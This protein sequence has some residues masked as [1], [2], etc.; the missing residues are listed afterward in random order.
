M[1]HKRKEL[2]HSNSAKK[3][4]QLNSPVDQ[5]LMIM[6]CFLI[7]LINLVTKNF[8]LD[9][10]F[11]CELCLLTLLEKVSSIRIQLL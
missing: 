5:N 2:T 9:S 1:I 7:F 8:F 4:N 3:I 6:T 11:Y 10:M